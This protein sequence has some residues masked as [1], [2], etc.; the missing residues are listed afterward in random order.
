MPP[1]FEGS[2]KYYDEISESLLD[3]VNDWCKDYNN[4]FM[5]FFQYVK[6]IFVFILL[7]IGLLT[8]LRLR[9]IYIQTR[10]RNLKKTEKEV[11][12]LKKVCLILGIVYIFLAFGILFNFLTYFLIWFFDPLPDKLIYNFIDFHGVIG[13]QYM[14]RIKD[15]N[16]S[17]YPCEK[18]F[19]LAVALGSFSSVLELL[20]SIWYLIHSNKLINNPKLALEGILGG[21]IGG[22]MFGFTTFMP[23]FL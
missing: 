1:K 23:F 5:I 14:N 10:L 4:F 11:D 16:N 8:L 6:Y 18:T 15:I 20:L 12:Q 2:N 19:C 21:V 17:Q 9:G 13:P 7:F 22:I 3:G